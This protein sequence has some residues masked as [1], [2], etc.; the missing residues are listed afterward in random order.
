MNCAKF[1]VYEKN[2]PFTKKRESEG[3]FDHSIS[4]GNTLTY[5]ITGIDAGNRYVY[6]FKHYNTFEST[7]TKI[8]SGYSIRKFPAGWIQK[9]KCGTK[10]LIKKGN[11][12]HKN[13][14]LYRIHDNGGRPFVVYINKSISFKQRVHIYKIPP[15]T[16]FP[17]NKNLTTRSALNRQYYTSLVKI[18]NADK[19]FIGK[20][21][22]NKMTC[23]NGCYGPKFNGNTI[24]LRIGKKYV[25]IGPEILEFTPPEEINMYYSSIGNSDVPYPVALGKQYVYFI[26]EHAYLPRI[27]FCPKIDWSDAYTELYTRLYYKTD[28]NWKKRYRRIIRFKTIQKRI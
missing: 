11:I 14:K 10:I 17:H 7:K 4:I 6:K 26:I 25:F 27:A 13:A 12:V 5:R 3:E 20:S 18:Y 9:Y 15:N 1:I 16:Y 24:L 21:V 8:P 2:L 28:K 22:K 19:V 23:F